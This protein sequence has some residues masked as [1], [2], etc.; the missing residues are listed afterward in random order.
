ME[1]RPSREA[2]SSCVGRSLLIVWCCLKC[3]EVVF[4][5]EVRNVLSFSEAAILIFAWKYYA[6]YEDCSTAGHGRHYIRLPSVCET[7]G[8][9][10]LTRLAI[11]NY[12]AEYIYIYL[13]MHNSFNILYVPYVNTRYTSVYPSV[14]PSDCRTLLSRAWIVFGRSN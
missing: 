9:A 10:V 12:S 2:N 4:D 3:C 7:R 11:N 6:K 1:Q 14:P 13:L 8:Q 5:R